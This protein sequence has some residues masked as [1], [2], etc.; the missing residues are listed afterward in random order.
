MN[1]TLTL[2]PACTCCVAKSLVSCWLFLVSWV[3]LSLLVSALFASPDSSSGCSWTLGFASVSDLMTCWLE[4]I[5]VCWDGTVATIKGKKHVLLLHWEKYF[6]LPTN[7]VDKSERQTLLNKS[8]TNIHYNKMGTNKLI[9]FLI[10]EFI[11]VC[12]S[13]CLPHFN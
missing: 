1:F 3:A 6:Y 2:L 13:I 9:M 12:I 7:S 8:T 11:L 5:E 4:A 10:L